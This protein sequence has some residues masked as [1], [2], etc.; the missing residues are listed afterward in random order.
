MTRRSFRCIV[1]AALSSCLFVR[2]PGGQEGK[3]DPLEG[4]VVETSPSGEIIYQP[5]PIAWPVPDIF[6][7]AF[8]VRSGPGARKLILGVVLN[9]VDDDVL[10]PLVVS[11]DG[12]TVSLKLNDHPRIDRS[13]CVPTA[14]QTI[15]TDDVLVRRISTAAKVQVVYK[16]AKV[17]LKT[18]LSPEDLEH[19]GG[20]SPF[21]T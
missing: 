4:I 9:G 8:M 7:S 17:Q 14:T 6:L 16:T 21:M 15:K 18:V 1:V 5:E 13:G 10:G 12:A 2:Q 19:S 3:S 20:S 11:I